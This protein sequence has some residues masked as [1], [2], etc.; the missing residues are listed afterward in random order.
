MVDTIA[1]ADCVRF[2]ELHDQALKSQSSV[3]AKII[4]MM[5]A[6][7]SS[8]IRFSDELTAYDYL[9]TKELIARSQPRALP[10]LNLNL[11]EGI[12]LEDEGELD[13]GEEANDK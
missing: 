11:T 1:L 3:I 9:L 8:D 5:S 10:E 7:L 6:S 12:A 4:T 2:L 13:N